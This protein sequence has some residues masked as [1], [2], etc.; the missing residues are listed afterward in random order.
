[1]FCLAFF[2]ILSV[3]TSCRNEARHFEKADSLYKEGSEKRHQKQSEM[4]AELFSQALLE[5]EKCDAGKEDVLRLKGKIEDDLG[6]MYWIHNMNE[7]ALPLHE[8]ALTIFRKTNDSVSLA[9]ALRNCGRAS[10][11]LQMLPEA[12]NYYEE[13]LQIA[14]AVEKDS[15]IND[16]RIELARDCY[17]ETEDYDK[18]I[19]YAEQVLEND[20]E[21]DQC[22]LILGVAY[23]YQGAD[24]LALLHLQESVKSNI[25]GVR[26]SA[27]QTLRYLAEYQ[28]NYEKALEYQELFQKN[29]MQADKEHR[30]EQVQ[31]I[32]AEYDLQAQKNEL[33]TAQRLKNVR[34]Y[35]F[36]SLLLIALRKP[37]EIWIFRIVIGSWTSNEG[38]KVQEMKTLQN[39]SKNGF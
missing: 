38:F 34:L 23:F 18:A 29:M 33:Q 39:P 28:G 6:V 17:L 14:Q 31:H 24:S 37:Y 1:M 35:L 12:Q 5:I 16:I 27:Y 8:D 10:A 11:S 22:H 13:A 9:Q 2:G 26:M 19:A 3:T 21:T 4:A 7:E 20:A 32:K 30:S 25:A 36:I 15:L